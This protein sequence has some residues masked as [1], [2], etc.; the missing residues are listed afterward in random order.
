MTVPVPA[1]FGLDPD[2]DLR[3][4]ASGRILLGGAPLRILRLTEAGAGTVRR[5]FRGEPVGSGA[6][7]GLLA[8]RLLDA[9]VAHPRPPRRSDPGGPAQDEPRH[10]LTVVLPVRDD[11]DGVALTLDRLFGGGTGPTPDQRPVVVVDDGSADPGRLGQAVRRRALVLRTGSG[12]GPGQARMVGLG[13]CSTEL[14]A[15]VDA[16]VTVSAEDLDRLVDHLGDPAV[17]AV[18]PRVA[19]RAGS[20]LVARYERLHSP[21]DL[22]TRPALV[23]PSSRVAYVPTACLVVRRAA[24]DAVGGF[25]PA[26]RYGEDV[27]LAWRLVDAGGSIRYDPSITAEHPPRPDLRRFVA[28]RLAYGSSAGPLARRHGDRVAPT[29]CSGWSVAVW[30]LVVAGRPG[31]GLALAAWTARAL[32]PKLAGLPEPMAEAVRL[33]AVGHLWAARTLSRQ[34]VRAW[35][36]VTALALTAAPR[37]GR[38]LVAVGVAAS[39]ADRKARSPAVAALAVVD[40]LAYG[41]GVWRS[42]GRRGTARAVLP[43]LVSW[44]VRR[45][46]AEPVTGR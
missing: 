36:P 14:V 3:V 7:E 23:R 33:T 24:L 40:D 35:W 31:A 37:S 45:R 38:R 11:A 2:L 22:G 44:P 41:F 5:W 10:R 16:G 43:G 21:L 4:V 30:G 19:S 1:G 25:D 6:G 15:F 18:A 26:L 17:V 13:R 12:G 32:R 42:L 9:G 8:R 28:Q 39:V 20:G 29:R 27:D 46:A 34:L